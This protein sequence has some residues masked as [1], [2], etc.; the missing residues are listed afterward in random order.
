VISLQ[1]DAGVDH[2]G[3]PASAA[4]RP[5]VRISVL[6][7]LR[8]VGGVAVVVSIISRSHR[9]ASRSLLSGSKCRSSCSQPN[10][11]ATQG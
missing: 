7:P 5:T 8:S 3:R 2:H 1:P 10:Q 9:R 11:V 4:D 6:R